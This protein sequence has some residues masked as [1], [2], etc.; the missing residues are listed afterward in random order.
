MV[1]T[2]DAWTRVTQKG[3]RCAL[4]LSDEIVALHVEAEGQTEILRHK[5]AEWV[6]QPAREA[7]R[8]VP[9]L[10]VLDSPY[11]F[12]IQPIL[13]FVLMLERDRPDRQIAVLIPELVERRWYTSLLHNHRSA[14]L[15]TLLLFKG[16][17]RI[18]V[19]NIPWYLKH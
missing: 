13:D 5:W 2:I 4:T 10:V 3:L 15:K 12:V 11:R 7:R 17:Q 9:R 16:D 1:I 14:V 8:P 6:E 18:T 19:I